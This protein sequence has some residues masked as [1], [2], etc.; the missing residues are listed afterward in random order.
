MNSDTGK[1]YEGAAIERA[2]ARGERIVPIS[3]RAAALVN[4]GRRA[5]RQ[6]LITA[7]QQ[8]KLRKLMAR[9]ERREHM[10]LQ[11]DVRVFW[12]AGA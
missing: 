3:P 9:A 5:R 4:E 1:V 7:R 10:H 8:R 11:H 6:G 12:Q 2:K